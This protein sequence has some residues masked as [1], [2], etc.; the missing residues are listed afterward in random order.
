MK[1]AQCELRFYVRTD[2]QT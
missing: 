2:R 1:I